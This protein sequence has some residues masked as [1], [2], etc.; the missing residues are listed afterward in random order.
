M[1]PPARLRTSTATEWAAASFD[2]VKCRPQSTQGDSAA[3][4]WFSPL[5][6]IVDTEPTSALQRLAA[7]VALTGSGRSLTQASS[8]T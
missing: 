8:S 5:A 2:A 7:V 1:N 4:S 6:H 3:V